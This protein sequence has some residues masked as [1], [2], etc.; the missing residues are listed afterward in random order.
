MSEKLLECPFENVEKDCGHKPYKYKADNGWYYVKCT[1]GAMG[2][3]SPRDLETESWNTRTEPEAKEPETE[4]VTFIKE[5]ERLFHATPLHTPLLYGDTKE[6]NKLILF[7]GEAK[8]KCIN[9]LI[10]LRGAVK[11]YH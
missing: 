9:L 2:P 4:F 10:Q 3:M 6:E 1:C 11:N 7:L 5:Y 8:L